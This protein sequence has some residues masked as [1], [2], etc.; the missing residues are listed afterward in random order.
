MLQFHI[1]FIHLLIVELVFCRFYTPYDLYLSNLS[2]CL[3]FTIYV[4]EQ[5]KLVYANH[6][7]GYPVVITN[8]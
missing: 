4:F 6:N 3:F 5:G 1:I 2:C 7:Y 8:I